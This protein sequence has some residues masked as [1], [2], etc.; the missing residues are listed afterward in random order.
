MIEKI[1]RENSINFYSIH[2]FPQEL[3]DNVNNLVK[4]K[5]NTNKELDVSKLTIYDLTQKIALLEQKKNVSKSM[6]SYERIIE[7]LKCD[8]EKQEKY[9]Q[10]V[11]NKVMSEVSWEKTCDIP[12]KTPFVCSKTRYELSVPSERTIEQ[13]KSDYEKQEKYYQSVQ[14]KVMSEV[15]QTQV[16]L[17]WKKSVISLQKT[18]F[19]CTIYAMNWCYVSQFIWICIRIKIILVYF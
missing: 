19:V 11:Q 1:P 9:Y 5:E 16:W 10:S 6:K 8:Y 17:S 12:Q 2:F 13:L 14:N 7:Q 15:S 18:R 4:I 3:R